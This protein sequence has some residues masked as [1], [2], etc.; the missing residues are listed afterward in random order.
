[1][2]I[3][4]FRANHPRRAQVNDRLANQNARIRDGVQQGTL[5]K[6]QAR[7]L[8]QEDVFVRRQERS[9]A[10]LNGGHLSTSEQQVLNQQENSISAQIA[11]AKGHS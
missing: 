7:G 1:M 3:T 4:S 11:A 6:D 8:H 9:M 10:A 5:T 2:S